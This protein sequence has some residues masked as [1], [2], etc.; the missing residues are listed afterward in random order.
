MKNEKCL[1]K[2]EKKNTDDTD[3]TPAW[4]VGRDNHRYILNK[5]SP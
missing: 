4:P 3:V 5:G 2:D 1:M